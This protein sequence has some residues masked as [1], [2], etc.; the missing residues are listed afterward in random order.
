MAIK[1]KC[2]SEEVNMKTKLIRNEQCEYRLHILTY[3][4]SII[5]T[6]THKIRKINNHRA[7]FRR[8]HTSG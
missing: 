2:I 1:K 5:Y 4:Y 7:K 8:T 6:Y 3:T